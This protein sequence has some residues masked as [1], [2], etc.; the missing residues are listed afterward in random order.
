MRSVTVAHYHCCGTIA[1]TQKSTGRRAT[2]A[3]SAAIPPG[4]RC[5]IDT[6]PL[7]WLRQ[8]WAGALSSERTMDYEL[9]IQAANLDEFEEE[10]RAFAAWYV[11]SQVQPEIEDITVDEGVFRDQVYRP[12]DQLL[13]KVFAI[14]L[15]Q[16]KDE[17]T[18]RETIDGPTFYVARRRNSLLLRFTNAYLPKAN[19]F[20]LAFIERC[21]EVWGATRLEQHSLEN[22]TEKPTLPKPA[23][24][25]G[26]FLHPLE[27]RQAIVKEYREARRKGEAPNKA[28]WA[29]QKY[30]MSAKTL[31][32]YEHEF[33]EDT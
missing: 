5:V 2:S 17:W 12:V 20:V 9:R 33:P 7:L 29:Q 14:N 28:A 3:R 10:L 26:K 24:D 13:T 21:K 32:R 19:P 27:S 16:R 4:D 31:S 30:G 15:Y 8:G 6:G 11:H 25:S 22:P 18:R 23:Q 1:T